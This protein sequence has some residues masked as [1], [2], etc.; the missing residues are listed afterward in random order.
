[1]LSLAPRGPQSAPEPRTV[2]RSG[3]S[4]GRRCRN[5]PSCWACCSLSQQQAFLHFHQPASCFQV[6]LAQVWALSPW[7]CAQDFF[8]SG[9]CI[10]VFCLSSPAWVTWENF[11]LACLSWWCKNMWQEVAAFCLFLVLSV[12]YLKLCLVGHNPVELQINTVKGHW[13]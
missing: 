10:R 3:A 11:H 9:I 4:S 2:D 8:P 6:K 7:S 13:L 1:M 5:Q 12:R